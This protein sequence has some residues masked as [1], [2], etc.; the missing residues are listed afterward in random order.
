MVIFHLFMF[1]NVKNN[2][3]FHIAGI[4]PE[5]PSFQDDGYGPPPSKWKGICRIGDSFGPEKCN[6]KIIGARWY[7]AGVDKALLNGEFLSPRDANDHGTHT[8]ST[9]AGNLVH[10]VSLH[11]LASGWGCE[12]RHPPCSYCCLQG[13]LGHSV[14]PTYLQWGSC[15]QSNRWCNPWRGGCLVYLHVRTFISSS[16]IACRCKGSICC[17]LSRKWRARCWDSAKYGAMAA[18]CCRSHNWSAISPQPSLLEVARSLWY[19]SYITIIL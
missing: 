3:N 7:T 1:C 16:L 8:A 5:S 14:S 13:L 4:W 18:N 9:A 11:G 17:V 15:C 6:G 19:D 10:N 2:I 12:R